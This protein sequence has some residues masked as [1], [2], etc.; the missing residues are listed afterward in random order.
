MGTSG[1]PVRP[2]RRGVPAAFNRYRAALAHPGFEAGEKTLELAQSAS[3][4]IVD[5]ARLRNA[6]SK[7]G[8]RGIG[9]T[10]D[11]RDLVETVAQDARG[12]HARQAAADHQSASGGHQATAAVSSIEEGRQ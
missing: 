12:A 9:V 11:D 8:R 2:K 1:P 3:E 6:R 4:Q 7:V 10:L 5:M